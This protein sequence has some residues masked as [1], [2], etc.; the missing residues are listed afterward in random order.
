MI[1]M[2]TPVKLCLTGSLLV[3]G[4]VC[5]EPADRGVHHRGLQQSQHHIPRPSR[6]HLLC[7]QVRQIIKLQYIM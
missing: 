6:H 5:T 1:L 4:G 2:K 3:H 7:L